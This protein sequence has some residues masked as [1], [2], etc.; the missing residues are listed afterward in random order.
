[1]SKKVTIHQGMI[2]GDLT[3]QDAPTPEIKPAA[4]KPFPVVNIQAAV[5]KAIA[6]AEAVFW[7]RLTGVHYIREQS[8]PKKFMN[9]LH[10]EMKMKQGKLD[11]VIAVRDSILWKMLKK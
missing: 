11:P 9:N 6:H 10:N 5:D 8:S 3:Q 7:M 4:K 1:M 2:F